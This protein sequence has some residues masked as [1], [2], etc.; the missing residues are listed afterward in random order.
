[1]SYFLLTC[2]SFLESKATSDLKVGIRRKHFSA[3]MGGGVIETKLRGL[4]I[5]YI[6]QCTSIPKSTHTIRDL[7]AVP[8]I[9]QYPRAL[10]T[11]SSQ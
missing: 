1:M 4:S 8:F 7:I 5:L 10:D 11:K 2:G 3:E 9:P 6:N